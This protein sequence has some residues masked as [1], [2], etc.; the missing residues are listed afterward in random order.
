MY[1]GSARERD[2]DFDQFVTL[3]RA[4]FEEGFARPLDGVRVIIRV[5]LERYRSLGGVRRMKSGVKR[6][7]SGDGKAHGVELES[8]EIILAG[9][10]ISTAGW[11]ETKV[12]CGSTVTD[13][14]IIRNTGRLSFGETISFLDCEPAAIG[15]E[16]TIVFFND[17]GSTEYYLFSGRASDKAK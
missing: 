16:E 5:L 6:I 10:V 3:W 1:Y 12:L 14:E 2:M 4:I 9:N 7:L 15:C 13:P 8:G 11:A 17:T